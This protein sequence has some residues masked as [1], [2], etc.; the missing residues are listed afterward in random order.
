MSKILISGYYG[1]NNIG[2]EA[3]LKSIID[4]IKHID[5]NADIVV[6]SSNPAFTSKT[7]NVRAIKRTN[8]FKIISE[9]MSADLVISGGGSLLQ[10]ITSKRSIIYYLSIINIAIMLN[11]KVAIYGQGIGPVNCIDNRNRVKKVLN[12]VD[13]IN[14]RDKDSKD[15]LISMGVNKDINVT[16]DSVF[17][18]DKPDLDISQHIISSMNIQDSNK[19]VGISVRPWKNRD[20]IIV[21]EISNVCKYLVEK[22]KYEIILIPF[23]F[24]SDINI[25]NQITTSLDENTKKKVHTLNKNISV[26]EYISLVGN[27]K[28]LIGMRLHA[29]IFA[30]LMNIP[31]IGLS[32]DPKID[33][34]LSMLGKKNAISVLEI[35]SQDV[36]KEIDDMVENYENILQDVNEKCENILKLSNQNR[37]ILM[38]LLKK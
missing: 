5:K 25:I 30:T 27:L 3:I 22:Y 1:F 23:H 16:V 13:F 28:F 7:Y 10:D 24:E 38:K 31:V 35:T 32:Y 15:E 6:L 17:G 9:M 33:T 12:K 2:D 21:Q 11:K 14:V 4:Q 8:V 26:H 34:F 29:L 18:M 19:I 36:I 37:D 20:K